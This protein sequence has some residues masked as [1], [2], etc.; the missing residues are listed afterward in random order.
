[1]QP[2]RGIFHSHAD[3]GDVALFCSRCG[4]DNPAVAQYCG[5]CGS[6]LDE[7]TSESTM[8]ESTASP[9]A[10]SE[11]VAHCIRCNAILLDEERCA[12]CGARQPLGEGDP[13]PWLLWLAFRVPDMLRSPRMAAKALPY[14]ADLSGIL[15]PMLAAM[16]LIPL[17]WLMALL[18]TLLPVWR[19]TRLPQP[20][21]GG[22]AAWLAILVIL[23][24]SLLLGYTAVIQGVM[25]I[26]GGAGSL[27]KTIRGL[28]LFLLPGWLAIGGWICLMRISQLILLQLGW[29][30]SDF[31]F[32]PIPAVY[33]YAL[34]PLLCAWSAVLTVGVLVIYQA[35]FLAELQRIPLAWSVL[36]HAALVIAL[37]GS[38][39]L[40]HHW[41][42][43]TLP[44]TPLASLQALIPGGSSC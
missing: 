34:I 43:P 9:A 29:I 7:A 42:M 20:D 40:G 37:I 16:M 33:A 22:V 11:P 38:L 23:G 5:D 12:T 26:F 19:S 8:G 31:T 32:A 6:L 25:A 39:I 10:T 36:L 14:R 28:A 2:Q 15:P 24:P 44:E 35:I 27:E 18:P 17:G 1:M 41:Q 13:D 4:A 30:T 3:N 21:G